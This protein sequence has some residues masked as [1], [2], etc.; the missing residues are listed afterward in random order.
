MN[1]DAKSSPDFP[2]RRPASRLVAAR[3]VDL[4]L[5]RHLPTFTTD[6]S[7]ELEFLLAYARDKFP[8]PGATT[9][10]AI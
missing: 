8:P 3:I 4:E 6:E 10:E 5:R 2:R 7:E 9:P 1:K